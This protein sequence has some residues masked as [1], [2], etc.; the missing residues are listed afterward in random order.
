MSDEKIISFEE[1][2][3][4]RNRSEYQDDLLSGIL[5]KDLREQNDLIDWYVFHRM[6]N[7]YKLF[8]H[9]LFEDNYRERQDNPNAG[10]VVA[11]GPDHLRSRIEGIEAALE[12]IGCPYLLLDAKERTFTQ[13]ARQLLDSPVTSNHGAWMAFE[14][15]LLRRDRVVVI[16]SI[17]RSRIRERKAS[18]ARSLIKILDDAHFNGIR[19]K[20]D[21][22]FIDHASFLEKSWGDLAPYITTM[23]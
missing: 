14:D 21:L 15:T 12:W 4:R 13:L 10:F 22:I 2:R 18:V 5:Q 3:S 11:F 9:T 8:L 17:S 23:A 20:A 16:S 6:F 1:F 19:P 7:A